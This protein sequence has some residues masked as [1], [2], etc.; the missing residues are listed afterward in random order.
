MGERE[1]VYE[2]RSDFSGGF[3]VEDVSVD[4]TVMRRLIFLDNPNV[5]QSEVIL[6][7]GK[8]LALS[9]FTALQFGKLAVEK[10]G[11]DS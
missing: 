5:I 10:L 8:P 6:K 3:V 2:G 11:L 1:T 7:E 4:N 9:T